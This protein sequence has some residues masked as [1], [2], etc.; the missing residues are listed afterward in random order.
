MKRFKDLL[1]TTAKFRR[2]LPPDHTKVVRP[3]PDAHIKVI[4]LPDHVGPHRRMVAPRNAPSMTSSLKG[5]PPS[6]TSQSPASIRKINGVRQQRHLVRPLVVNQPQPPSTASTS[7]SVLTTSGG[8]RR[9]SYAA[10]PKSFLDD[11]TAAPPMGVNNPF[12]FRA[13]DEPSTIEDEDEELVLPPADTPHIIQ[14]EI[15]AKKLRY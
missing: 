11:L 2:P 12:Q 7:P 10:V 14:N 4:R 13:A 8:G 5:P 3:P 15:V 6:T 9:N 1:T